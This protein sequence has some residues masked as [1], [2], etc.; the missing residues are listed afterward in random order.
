MNDNRVAWVDYAKGICIIL[1]VMMHT[2]NH[3]E[4]AFS[5]EGWMR[6]IV[7]FARPFRMPD[8]FLIAGLFLS[9]TIRG[10][11]LDYADRKIVHFVYFYV[12]WLTLQLPVLEFQT[13]VTAPV[14][15]LKIWV[16]SCFEPVNS[17]WFVHMLAIFY[18]VTWMLRQVPVWIVLAGAFT[19]QTLYQLD[20]IHTG[21]NVL[22]RFSN[23]YVYFF[24]G[25]AF[26]PHIFGFAARAERYPVRG[27][28]VLLAWAVVN[29]QLVQMHLHDTPITSFVLGMAGACAICI[30]SALL[31]RYQWSG[32]LR[33]CGRNSI[34]IY[35]SFIFPLIAMEKVVLPATGPVFGSVGWS[36]ALTLAVSVCLP[37]AFHAMIRNT[38]ANMLYKRPAWASISS[39]RLRQGTAAGAI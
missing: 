35:L 33:Y 34:V 19:L 23:R 10:P 29:W 9:R 5:S 1:V 30:I 13:L 4:Y 25:Y 28:A 36:S 17:L 27:A 32:F 18:V 16:K 20:M 24:I 8:F 38:P 7:D 12:L 31:A 26:A 22:D 37:L 14:N 6:P 2:V 11:V 21:W 15:F 3:V 39:R